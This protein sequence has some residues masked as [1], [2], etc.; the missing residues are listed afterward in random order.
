[1]VRNRL[2][3]YEADAERRAAIADMAR[4]HRVAVEERLH[5]T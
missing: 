4:K 5:R 1:V 2:A 3:D